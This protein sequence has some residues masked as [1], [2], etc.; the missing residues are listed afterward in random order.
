MPPPLETMD[1]YQKAVLWSNS[2]TGAGGDYGELMRGTPREIIVRWVNNRGL[3]RNA[4]GDEVHIDASVVAN[5]L[6]QEGSLMWLGELSD[7]Y[8][9]GSGDQFASVMKVV[10]NK[11]TPSIHARY[12]RYTAGLA[13]YRSTNLG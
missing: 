11:D 13:Y 3:M 4:N 2:G 5:E 8:G 10:A 7:W 12:R 1:R 6:I 9:T